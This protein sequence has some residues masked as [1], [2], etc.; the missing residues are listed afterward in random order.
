[1]LNEFN[2]QLSSATEQLNRLE[3]LEA[4]Q[5]TETGS[6]D[7]DIDIKTTQQQQRTPYGGYTRLHQ[8]KSSYSSS[9]SS[10][11]TVAS[12]P[13]AAANIDPIAAKHLQPHPIRQ[14]KTTITDRLDSNYKT[15]SSL[16]DKASPT[17]IAV[18]S[19]RNKKKFEYLNNKIK[20]LDERVSSLD[21]SANVASGVN[22]G[23]G[24]EAMDL[25]IQELKASNKNP[26]AN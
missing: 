10:S 7:R 2:K 14:A 5:E 24:M 26:L 22:G 21:T 20:A 19:D 18:E 25:E 11:R 12:T 16:Q 15:L 23:H 3:R 4:Q 6:K 17:R 1:M 13:A 9:T 8:R